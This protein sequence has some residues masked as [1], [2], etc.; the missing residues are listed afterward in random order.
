MFR[1]LR[2][3]PDLNE[4]ERDKR[5]LLRLLSWI[6]IGVLLVGMSLAFLFMK[7]G[8]IGAVLAIGSMTFLA[9]FALFI[10]YHIALY[11]C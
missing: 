9:G 7:L 2:D 11:F 8:W 3:D 5:K 4:D 10:M 1:R 6:Y